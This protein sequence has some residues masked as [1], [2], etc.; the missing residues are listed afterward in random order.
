MDIHCRA[1]ANF[2]ALPGIVTS[3][4]GVVHGMVSFEAFELISSQIVWST[5]SV[6]MA[7]VCGITKSVQA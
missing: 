7:V 5:E 2:F 6:V 1:K 3:C 4:G